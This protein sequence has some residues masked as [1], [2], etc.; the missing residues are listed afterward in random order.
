MHLPTTTVAVLPILLFSLRTFAAPLKA[1]A[2]PLWLDPDQDI[3]ANGGADAGTKR[4]KY[5]LYL[6]PLQDENDFNGG[7]DPGTKRDV[8]P[9]YLAPDQGENDFNGGAV[10]DEKRAI[11]EPDADD[12]G[13]YN[14][15]HPLNGMADHNSYGG[16]LPGVGDEPQTSSH[17]GAPSPSILGSGGTKQMLDALSVSFSGYNKGR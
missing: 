12:V 2:Y 5:P 14:G 16:L 10:P 4:D 17:L 11:G 15:P 1:P 8:Y 3:D 13:T 6:D 9:E 7:A